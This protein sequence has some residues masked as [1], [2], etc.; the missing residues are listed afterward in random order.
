MK[1]RIGQGID[2]HP[3]EVGRPLFIG[4]V[5]IPSAKGL[6][7]HSDADVLI[8][9]LID[10]LFG[11]AGL[12]D[13]GQAF[14]NTESAWKNANSMDLLSRAW[15]QVS[16]AGW[17]IVN[18]DLSILAEAPKINPHIPAMKKII[19]STLEIEVGAIGIKATT[20]ER[21]GFVGREEGIM[22]FAVVLLS[23]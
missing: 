10:A 23:A 19:A 9:A 20:T 7:G 3:F 5:N 14:P 2:I 21:L 15:E 4:G 8:H 13:I 12:P 1:L 6:A 11:A 18:I 17:K 22:A 16:R